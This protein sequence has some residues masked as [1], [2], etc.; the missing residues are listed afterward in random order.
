MLQNVKRPK[1]AK[2]DLFSYEIHPQIGSKFTGKRFVNFCI[3]AWDFLFFGKLKSI[4]G[5]QSDFE[6]KVRKYSLSVMFDFTFPHTVYVEVKYC[7]RVEILNFSK[8]S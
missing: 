3:R 8:T 2:M 4:I 1:G 5:C 6:L 7:N